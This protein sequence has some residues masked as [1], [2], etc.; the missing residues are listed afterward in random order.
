[1]AFGLPLFVFSIAGT[2]VGTPPEEP[3]PSP[4][5]GEDPPSLPDWAVSAG[6]LVYDTGPN[7]GEGTASG[8]LTHQPHW[9]L[10]FARQFRTDLHRSTLGHTFAYARQT[11]ARR[12][13]DC[14]WRALTTAEADTTAAELEAAKQVPINWTP[15]GK[16][17]GTWKVEGEVERPH[18][19]A[20]IDT[21]RAVLVET[22]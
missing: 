7:A 3:P 10:P 5:P 14:T 15:P 13:Y 8:T 12:R 6:A 9:A 4:P 19:G 1:M 22:R 21:I 18:A 17:A 2:A 16:T 11:D 20:A